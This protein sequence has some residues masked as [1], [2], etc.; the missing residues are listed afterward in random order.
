MSHHVVHPITEALRHRRLARGKSTHTIAKEAGINRNTLHSHES[1]K[2][3]ALILL[4]KWAKSL[5]YQLVLL[6]TSSPPPPRA[7]GVP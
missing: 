1:V 4:Q 7:R 3:T 2:F 6:D 5:D